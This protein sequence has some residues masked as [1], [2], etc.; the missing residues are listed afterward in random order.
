MPFSTHSRGKANGSRPSVSS[1]QDSSSISSSSGTILDTTHYPELR[2]LPQAHAPMACVDPAFAVPFDMS[3]LTIS[4]KRDHNSVKA[5]IVGGGIAGLAT[6]IMMGMAGMEYEILERT[7]GKEPNTACAIVLGP[8]V[9]R[10]MEQMELLPEIE[11]LSKPISGLTI[12]DG[13]CR[14]MGRVDGVETERYGYDVR[15]IGHNDF[16]QIL[17]AKV[18]KSYLHRGKVVVDI[19]Q[20]PNGVSCHCSD[21]SIYYGDITIGA[22][23]AHSQTR[24]RM[25]MQLKEQGKLPEADMEAS[26]FDH[27]AIGGVSDP[28]DR[29]IY[30]TCQEPASEFQVIYIKESPY[31]LWY[32][33]MTE[34]RVAWGISHNQPPKIKHHPYSNSS[35]TPPSTHGSPYDLSLPSHDQPKPATPP[36]S[37]SHSQTKIY[38]DWHAPAKIDLEAQYKDLLDAHCAIGPGTVRDFVTHTPK[39]S[40]VMIDLEERLYKTWYHGR[41]VLIGD[42]CHQH[43]VIGG[44]GAVQSL[45]DG[46]CLVNLLY[47]MDHNTPNA[48]AKAFKR[49]Q[50]KRCSL[51]KTSIEETSQIANIFHGQG[52]RAGIMRKFMFNSVWSF[53]MKNDKFNNNRPQLSFLPFVEDRGLCKASRQKISSKMP[54]HTI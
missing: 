52:L 42:A 7:T 44:Q 33:P 1:S 2:P 38:D 35:P 9:L 54:G 3:I 24:E 20:N 43:L 26:L 10:L 8:P 49:Y 15:I 45:L 6:A 19:L 12:V 31:T 21:G 25:Y 29:N 18:S 36:L 34:N 27:V 32:L 28:L 46:V 37:R 5:V 22:D 17:L 40:L 23:G 13:E 11:R 53:N 4:H 51:A 47:D 14:R 50:A 16:H 39:K 48:L 30:T 41:I